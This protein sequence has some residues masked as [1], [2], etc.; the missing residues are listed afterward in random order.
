MAAPTSFTITATAST[1]TAPW[2]GQQ[3]WTVTA[4]WG[5]IVR[6]TVMEALEQL[7]WKAGAQ[8]GGRMQQYLTAGTTNATEVGTP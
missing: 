8:Y 4:P 7:V 6:P 3:V 5:T 2:T 1:G